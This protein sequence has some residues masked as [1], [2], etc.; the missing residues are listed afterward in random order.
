MAPGA[1][2]TAH[3]G[4]CTECPSGRGDARD[5]AE[6]RFWCPGPLR[7]HSCHEV[8]ACSLLRSPGRPLSPRPSRRPTGVHALVLTRWLDWPPCCLLRSAGPLSS[9]TTQTS[10]CL[11]RQS[12]GSLHPRPAQ[13]SQWTLLEDKWLDWSCALHSTPS[14]CPTGDYRG[15]C[16]AQP[17]SSLF[18]GTASPVLSQSNHF[19][20]LTCFK[21]LQWQFHRGFPLYTWAR[22]THL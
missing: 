10:P 1:G 15:I 19:P 21:I 8:C 5:K 17:A 9:P 16:S 18:S 4:S 6:A 11:R 14:S 13:Q 3:S 20:P 2:R 22:G 7:Y 12:P